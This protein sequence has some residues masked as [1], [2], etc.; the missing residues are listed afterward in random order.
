LMSLLASEAVVDSRGSEILSSEEVEDLK[1]VRLNSSHSHIYPNCCN[2]TR[3][4]GSLHPGFP[5]LL[6]NSHWKPRS[7]TLPSR[8]PKSTRPTR[9]CP[10]RHLINLKQRIAK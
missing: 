10:N 5:R 3:N 2:G 4:I 7:V 8:Y 9:P 1:K 6:R